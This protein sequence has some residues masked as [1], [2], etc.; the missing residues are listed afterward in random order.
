MLRNVL[1]TMAIICLFSSSSA[2]SAFEL[3]AEV[4]S[5]GIR[6]DNVTQSNGKMVPSGW[7][8]PPALQVATAWSAAT[9]SASPMTSMI[10]IGGTGQ[11]SQPI[12]IDIS[13]VEYNT[14]G[15]NYTITSNS[16]GGG[17][18]VDNVTLPI[19]QVE[20]P[21]CISS[22]KLV[23]ADKSSPFIFFRPI[24]EINDSDVISALGGLSEGIY[25]ASVPINVRYY[26][27]NNG[28]TT[29]RNINDV[30]IFSFDYQP[31]QLDSISVFGDGVMEPD[32]DTVNR[33]ITSE[34]TFN[35]SAIGYFDDGIVL[36]M[37]SQ[38]YELVHSSDPSSTIPYNINCTQC[39]N[40]NL[41][42]QGTLLNQVTS[43]SEGTGT[44][45]DIGFDLIFD[46]DIDGESV[47][48]GDYFDEVTI[49]LE[50][51]M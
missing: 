40:I 41:V 3:H 49:M 23:S 44:Q 31:V 5:G 16:L 1:N 29:F 47:I 48:S 14:T 12:D 9:F 4:K 35:I 2:W 32:Y 25:S 22:T 6:W 30:M 15:I 8:T 34:T 18:T 50:P 38:T 26:Y 27:E 13:G 51:G 43:I 19:V 39:N 37:P 28:I 10:L 7:E 11:T 24:F 42:E 17:C 46:Y 21:N 45:T 20:G 36:T 33:R